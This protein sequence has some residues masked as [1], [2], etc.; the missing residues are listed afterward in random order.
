METLVKEGPLFVAGSLQCIELTPDQAPRLQRFLEAN[1]E[2][3]LAVNGGVPGPNEAHEEFEL[4]LPAG[5]I[6]EKKWLLGFIRD[7]GSMV[8]MADLISNLFTEGVWHIGLF[9][10]AT[11]LHGSGTAQALYGELESWMR[12]RGGRWARLG[13]VE[14][15]VRA[16]RF[17]ERAGYVDVRRRLGIEMGNKVNNLRVMAKPLS[18]RPLSEYLS[19]VARDRPESP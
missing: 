3:Y 12:S 9:I 5:W 1:P 8:G 7:D 11:S 14:G 4:Q 15:N 18:D 13:V 16:E 19:V 6:C 17:W 10:V 2:Y